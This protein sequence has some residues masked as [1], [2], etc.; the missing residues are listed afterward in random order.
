MQPYTPTATPPPNSSVPSPMLGDMISFVLDPWADVRFDDD[1]I[2]STLGVSTCVPES[3][4]FD[5]YN[6]TP[7]ELLDFS[8]DWNWMTPGHGIGGSSQCSPSLRL[9]QGRRSQVPKLTAR[10]SY[11]PASSP[12]SSTS[13]SSSAS[14]ESSRGSIVGVCSPVSPG[15]LGE[16]PRIETR[17]PSTPTTKNRQRVQP[18]FSPSPS[19]FSPAM[20]QSPTATATSSTVDVEPPI[21]ENDPA[22]DEDQDAIGEPEDPDMDA[23]YVADEPNSLY[24]CTCHGKAYKRKGDVLRHLNERRLPEVCSGCGKGFPRKDPRIRYVDPSLLFFLQTGTV[25]WF[26]NYSDITPERY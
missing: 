5:A 23:S 4:R 10:R 16:L 9:G 26:H 7:S 11:S 21:H 12:L 14:E 19:H 22:T 24:T 3:E 15:T 13:I 8:I 17:N 20:V 25:G 2:V 1:H 18:P 6:S